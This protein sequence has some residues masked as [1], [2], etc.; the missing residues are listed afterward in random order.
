MTPALASDIDAEVAVVGAGVVGLAV[1]AEL[2]R[3]RS[4][5]V[6]ERHEGIARETSSHNSQVLHAGIFYPTGSLKHRLCLEGNRLLYEWCEA[7]GVPVR[8]I[9]KLIVAVKE[10]EIGGLDGV[11]ER[12][13]A[14][15]IPGVSRLTGTQARSLEPAL[16][17]VAALLSESSGVVDVFALA[18]SLESAAREAGALFA[19]RHKLLGVERAGGAFRLA[20]RDPDGGAA[21]LHCV[22]LVNSAGHGAPAIAEALGY[23]L[24]GAEAVPVMRQHV[25][26]GRYYDLSGAPAARRVSRLIYPLPA[27]GGDMGTQL[28]AAGG[29]GVH[30]TVDTE[31]A[32]SLGPDAEWLPDGASLDYRADDSRRAEFLAAGQRLLPGL[33]DDEIAPGQV[34]YRPK[35]QRPGEEPADFLLWADGGYVHLGGIESP[36][37]TA[38][39]AL[40]RAVAHL[41]R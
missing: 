2:A 30:L 32:V 14:N 3:E 40:A 17:V 25:N 8:R 20:L 28:R 16:A 22:A 10:A 37:L 33:R 34:G 38:C 13:R 1:A 21:E 15:E 12:A 9:G 26:R 31:G 35:L 7:R 4:V 39:M 24:D 36:G 27:H 5:V 19:Y 6:I 29:L 23:P 41:L 18:R 11:L